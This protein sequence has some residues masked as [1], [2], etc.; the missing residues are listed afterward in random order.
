[1]SDVQ[2]TLLNPTPKDVFLGFVI[3]DVRGKGE[4]Q[5]ISKRKINFIERNVNRYSRLI[6]NTGR[7]K[8]IKDHIDLVAIISE[9]S[10]ESKNYKSRD[11]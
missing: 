10:S 8:Y 6:N 7:L 2:R 9:V 4:V 5:K 3:Y 1:M 11:K